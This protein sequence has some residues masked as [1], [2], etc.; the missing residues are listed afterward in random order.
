MNIVNSN[1][2]K[3]I[4]IIKNS[5][6]YFYIKIF[7][8][9]NRFHLPSNNN[10]Y[11]NLIIMPL[12]VKER[13]KNLYIFINIIAIL[14][15]IFPAS[16]KAQDVG[17]SQF[18]SNMIHLNP[19][20]AGSSK[21]P[22][23][24]LNYRNQWPG[25]EA[26]F[27]TYSV[28]YDQYLEPISGGLGAQI[29]QDIQGKN[30]INT[31][32]FNLIYSRTTNITNKLSIKTGF[33]AGYYRRSINWANFV[34]PDMLS[35][36]GSRLPTQEIPSETAKN[37]VDFSSGIIGFGKNYYFGLAIHNLSQAE[38]LNNAKEYDFLIRKYT[39]HGGMSFKTGNAGKNNN[40][41]LSLN[42]IIEKQRDFGRIN[43]GAY[44]GN[45]L[46]TGGIWLQ[47]DFSFLPNSC[48]F[49]LGSSFANI[50][51]AYSFDLPITK[52]GLQSIGAHEI[53]VI[54]QFPCPYKIKKFTTISC[55]DF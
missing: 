18:Y 29:M 7:N 23:M 27:K 32:N 44:Y 48:I 17:F 16:I 26:A 5:K 14:L 50:K 33:Q 3:F 54:I 1:F 36:T 43:T 9:K 11:T 51:F 2:L 53:S 13:K 28:S 22:R 25:I 34:F 12:M 39:L 24:V 38:I 15:T 46:I 37:Y 10:L 31:I 30:A 8:N 19:A 41:R 52:I 55:P 49:M 45:N 20:L 35:L 21:C 40:S 6:S 47:Q 42:M 4:S